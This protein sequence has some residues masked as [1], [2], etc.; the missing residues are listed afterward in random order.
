LILVTAGEAAD[1]STAEKPQPKKDH[2]FHG[3]HGWENAPFL[4]RAT[5]EIRGEK[6]VL[7]CVNLWLSFLSLHAIERR[8]GGICKC[9]MNAP[10]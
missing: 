6:S 8:Y 9:A 10:S 5:R 3:F 7:I 4:I 2:G 1:R